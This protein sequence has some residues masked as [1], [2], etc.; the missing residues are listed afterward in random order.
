MLVLP[1]KDPNEV[2]DYELD[3]ARYRLEEGETITDSDFTVVAG[4]VV[5]DSKDE[6]AGVTKVWLSGGT[7][8]ESCQILNRITT[9]A[10]RIYD[11]TAKLRIRTK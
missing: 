8:G 2:V 1:A 11:Q 9:S 4:T 7:V 6:V 5:I 3:W 10:G